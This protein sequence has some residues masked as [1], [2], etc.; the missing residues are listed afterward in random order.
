MDCKIV[1]E[2]GSAWTH[3]G[4][5]DK[6]DFSRASPREIL[7]EAAR[8]GFASRFL[9]SGI[10]NCP[11]PIFI[12]DRE[13]RV[14][15]WNP[16]VAK[17]TGHTE[18]EMVGGR[19]HWM[20]FYE[21]QR[22]TLADLIVDGI[23]EQEVDNLYH[24]KYQRSML[25]DGG[26]EVVDFFPESGHD[27]RWLKFTAA[28]LKDP[29]GQIVGAME[30][31]QDVTATQRAE[32]ALKENQGFL[33]QIVDGSSVPTLVID[34][35]HR[36]THWNR[37]CE[38][39]TGVSAD[40]VVGTREQWRPF[41]PS[42]RPIM[43]DLI[44]DSA[45][46]NEVDQFYHGKFRPSA[47]VARA[48]E[49][50]DFFPQLGD[51]GRWLFFTAAPLSD[52]SGKFIGAIETLQ[53]ITDQKRA[54][55]ALRDSEEKYRTMSITDA[56]TSLYNSR[57]FYEQIEIEAER[58]V[59]YGRPLS[60]LLLDLD[61]FKSINDTHGHLEGDKV[62]SATAKIIKRC[63]RNCDTAYRYGGEELTVLLPETGLDA[64]TLLA[65]RICH[66]IADSPVTT[67]AGTELAVTASIGVTEYLPDEPYRNFIRRA[68]D[69]VYEAK[70]QGKNRAIAISGTP[71]RAA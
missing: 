27:G 24:G 7:D 47:L 4:S 21:F 38:I 59:R 49:A 14:S 36:V 64:A 16:A 56:L 35:E 13:H 45:L 53:D 18:S 10:E 1:V 17:L 42:E 8:V 68:D 9:L 71:D 50:E 69:G 5:M 44:L 20:A 61:N 3:Y 46:E 66:A 40:E 22:A 11:I 63:L 67:A 29:S 25:L 57:Y 6:P 30:I 65:E 34:R 15:S 54:E 55:Q 2:D 19:K 33:K 70:R 41:Y 23:L 37:A 51:N 26:F 52:A 58:A 43:A 32:L 31:L 12:I 28:P 39:I 60:M 48:F 62:L